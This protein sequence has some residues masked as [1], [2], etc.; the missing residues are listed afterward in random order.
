M[1]NEV[2]VETTGSL[3]EVRVG[4]KLTREMYAVFV[5]RVEEEIRKHGKLDML[6]VMK[7]F[8][9]WTAGALWDD[10]KFDL[11]HFSDIRRLAIVGETKWQKGMAVFCRPFTT[12]KIRYFPTTEVEEA[13][14]WLSSAESTVGSGKQNA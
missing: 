13:R 8:H 14:R 11:K 9:G 5:P 7:D 12:A 4:G 3:L 1:K 2:H 10:L 6:F